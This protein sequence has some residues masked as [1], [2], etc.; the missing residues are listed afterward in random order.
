MPGLKPSH[1]QHGDEGKQD[2]KADQRDEA[3]GDADRPVVA[4]AIGQ[5]FAFEPFRLPLLSGVALNRENASQVVGKK[6]VEI[7]RALAYF[8]ITRCQLLLE[9]Q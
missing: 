5:T 4:A 2:G 3:R 8:G 1:H 6:V 7:S 9:A